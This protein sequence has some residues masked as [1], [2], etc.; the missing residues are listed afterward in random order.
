MG[1]D[2][3]KLVTLGRKPGVKSIKVCEIPKDFVMVREH[4]TQVVVVDKL[5]T[6]EEDRLLKKAI[7]EDYKHV[8]RDV[9][10]VRADQ[11]DKKDFSNNFRGKNV[12]AVELRTYI[13]EEKYSIL[14]SATAP[15]MAFSKDSYLK[16]NVYEKVKT[17]ET[18]KNH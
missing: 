10:V 5:K 9:I 12:S 7:K 14:R 17:N 13:S 16:H 3:I 8:F 2:S 1:D 6:A 11:I 15:V 18:D 4:G